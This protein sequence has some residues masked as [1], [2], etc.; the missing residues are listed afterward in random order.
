[1]SINNK[2][3]SFTIMYGKL[4]SWNISLSSLTQTLG[5]NPE[6]FCVSDISGLVPGFSGSEPRTRDSGGNPSTGTIQL[7]LYCTHVY[8]YCSSVG[9][10]PYW[11][12]LVGTLLYRFYQ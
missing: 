5:W 2:C 8:R 4:K 11:C 1:M 6:I 10:M 3:T 7:K 12:Y 9:L